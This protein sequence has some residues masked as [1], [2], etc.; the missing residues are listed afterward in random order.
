MGVGV[1]VFLITLGLILKFAIQPD[2]MTD[3][4]DI[5]VIGVILIIVGGV[6][7][8]L[9]LLMMSR[10]QQRQPRFPSGRDERTYDG[11]NPPRP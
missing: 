5:H 6:T 11:D 9:Q 3:P 10:M 1:S 8:A 4:V 7:F 2:A